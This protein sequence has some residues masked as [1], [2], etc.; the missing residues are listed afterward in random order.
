MKNLYSYKNVRYELYDTYIMQHDG[1]RDF[2]VRITKYKYSIVYK[3]YFLHP[4]R[5]VTRERNMYVQSLKDG[6]GGLRSQSY[7]YR[8]LGLNRRGLNSNVHQTGN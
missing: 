7:K 8:S 1:L 4:L 6:T 3:V 2:G 5:R